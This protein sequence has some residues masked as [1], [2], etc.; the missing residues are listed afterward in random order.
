VAADS[1]RIFTLSVVVFAVTGSPL[2]GAL[3]LGAGF[4]PQAI[5]GLLLGALADRVR[6]RRLIATGYT[7]EAVLAAVLA[8]LHPPAVW[9]IVVVGAVA[10][11]VPVFNG[12][13]GR[14]TAVILTGDAYV[15]ARAVSGMSTA[16]AQLV[17]L[18]AG[19]AVIA[20]IGARPAL[21]V[22]AGCYL[23]AGLAI[24]LGLPDAPP[25][26][27]ATTDTAV[28]ESWRGSRHLLADRTVRRLLVAQWLPM[29]IAVGAEAL[30]VPYAGERRFQPAAAGLL[31]AALPTGML[32][33]GLVVGRF[34]RPA[35][36]EWLSAPM[37]VLLGAPLPLLLLGPSLGVAVLLLV[38]S[39]SGLAFTVGL[40][41]AFVDAVPQDRSGLA[42]TLLSTGLMT[43]QGIGSLVAGA[44]A[45]ITSPAIAIAAAGTATMLAA[46]LARRPKARLPV[47]R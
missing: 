13:A 20:A 23:L 33:G 39:G 26:A 8:L 42:F 31:L 12:A 3:A 22:A 28:M 9:Y 34:V 25:P 14:L 37:V 44:A 30:L 7:L 35:R 17:G 19:G 18:A 21:V 45:E 47:R 10:F 41:R 16:V 1:L 29:A 24:R 36:R 38:L 32:L 46:P 2:L 11:V 43:L 5:G 4:L 15:L 27:G 6:P 40:Q